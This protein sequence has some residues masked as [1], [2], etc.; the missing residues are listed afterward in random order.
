[1]SRVLNALGDRLLGAL[2]PKTT[3]HAITC[4][5]QIVGQS[6]SCEIYC[7]I[8]TGGRSEK[9]RRCST[10]TTCTHVCYDCC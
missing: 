10:Q 8:W 2:L 9:M 6:G 7:Y 4:R 5:G 1:M 3:A